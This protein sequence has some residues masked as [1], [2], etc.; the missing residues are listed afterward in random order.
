MSNTGDES[1]RIMDN[2]KVE[3]KINAWE[4]TNLEKIGER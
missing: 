1:R 2:G 4:R 3:T